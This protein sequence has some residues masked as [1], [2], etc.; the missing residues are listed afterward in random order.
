[1]TIA[2]GAVCIIAVVILL[3]LIAA[4]Q[5]VWIALAAAGGVGILV[6]DGMGVVN[7]TFQDSPLGA[8]ATYSLV[9]VP[10][11]IL[12]GIFARRAGI[13]SDVFV[14]ASRLTRRIPG[15][16]GV[17]TILACGGF[18]AVTGSSVATVATVGRLAVDEMVKRGYRP[19]SAAAIVAA[20]GTLGVLIPPSII[21]VIFASLVQAS[22][23][24]LLLAGFV[25]G[26][27]TMAAYSTVVI[28]Q[29]LRNP[30][31]PVAA[32]VQAP[33]SVGA[34]AAR[35]TTGTALHEWPTRQS[36][37]SGADFRDDPGIFRR[38]IPGALIAI[39]LMVVVL[40]GMY[41]GFFTA[42]ESGAVAAALA[43]VIMAI[44]RREDGLNKIVRGIRD[45]AQ[46]AGATTAM[47]FAL[48]VGGTIFGYFLIKSGLPTFIT[49]QIIGLDLSATAVVIA[50]LLIMMVL[51]FFLEAYSIMVITIPLMW[52]AMVA[53]DVDPIWF[54]I[55][56][57]KA[58]EIGMLTPP[59]G[60]NVFVAAKAHPDLTVEGVFRAVFPFVIAEVAVIAL[61][62]VFPE[63]V[64][65]LPDT[66]RG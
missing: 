15:G 49:H 40:G 32:A 63:I 26:V 14:V 28:V 18:A 12:M 2:V 61:F 7:A 41:S 50:A 31:R 45:S 30:R 39:V 57:V 51:G 33:V 25:P 43:L 37:P 16:L 8:V 4:E 62:I 23:G 20:G 36:M 47:I 6:L 17:A 24:K 9:I 55:L 5:P 44:R 10:M 52:P 27:V 48:L 38:H 13:A 60:I 29:T 22:V 34:S 54:G 19:N 65:W 53:L 42:T 58:I 64:T 1:M 21:M 11:F 35:T 66:L 46:E 59:F 56:T 3:A